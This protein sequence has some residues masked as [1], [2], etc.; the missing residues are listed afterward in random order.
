M[1]SA[2]RPNVEHSVEHHGTHFYI[3][4]NDNATNFKL[5]RAPDR[6][7]K[8][9]W[10]TVIPPGP[11]PRRLRRLPNHLVLMEREK[12]LTR[13][14]VRDFASGTEHHIAMDEP[15]YTVRWAGTRSSTPARCA[16][17]TRRSSPRRPCTTTKCR[18]KSAS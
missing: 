13:F 6:D 14:R 1:I 12:A 16:T 4:T 8:P 3:H 7:P 5:V 18:P 2:G 11:V 15:V 10:T 9:N 17:S